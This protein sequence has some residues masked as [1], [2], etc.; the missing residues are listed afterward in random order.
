MFVLAENRP[1]RRENN[2]RQDRG[3]RG[4]QGDR[5]TFRKDTDFDGRRERR[6]PPREGGFDNKSFGSEFR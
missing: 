5:V 6:G 1:P 2:Q 4:E 3:N